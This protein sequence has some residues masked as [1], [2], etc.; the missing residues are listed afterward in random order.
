MLFRNAPISGIPLPALGMCSQF[1]GEGG[2]GGG[3]GAGAAAAPDVDVET[4][5]VVDAR[6]DACDKGGGEG[7]G[8]GEGAAA[9][10]GAGRTAFVATRDGRRSRDVSI[11]RS[12]GRVSIG[13]RATRVRV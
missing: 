13:T 6:E 2:A 11:A 12:S 1:E 9:G 7:G 3:E 8:E 10:A 5:A 4:D